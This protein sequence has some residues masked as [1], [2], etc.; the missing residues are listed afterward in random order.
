MALSPI[1]P[2]LESAN[3]E[4]RVSDHDRLKRTEAE[5]EE[6]IAPDNYS[7]DPEDTRRF[8]I[9]D[10]G[11]TN[12]K[13]IFQHLFRLNRPVYVPKPA[14]SY[15]LGQLAENESCFDL[16]ELDGVRIYGNRAL[17]TFENPGGTG[18][19]RLFNLSGTTNVDIDGIIAECTDY[20]IGTDFEHGVIVVGAADDSDPCTDIRIRIEA[21]TCLAGVEFFRA[22]TGRHT[23][24][25]IDIET[26]SCYYG[27]VFGG[28]GDIVRGRIRTTGAV[29]SYF[30]YEVR[31]HDVEVLANNVQSISGGDCVIKAFSDDSVTENIRVRYSGYGTNS[32]EPAV[33]IET[34]TVGTDTCAIRNIDLW[35][36]TSGNSTGASVHFNATRNASNED[37]TTCTIDQIWIRGPLRQ[38]VSFTTKPTSLGRILQN[39]GV[40]VAARNDMWSTDSRGWVFKQGDG[41]YWQCTK[42]SDSI[43]IDIPVVGFLGDGLEFVLDLLIYVNA[44]RGL[45][46]TSKVRAQRTTVAGYTASNAVTLRTQ[47]THYNID[48]STPGITITV[49]ASGGN[50]RIAVTGADITSD[51]VASVRYGF[52]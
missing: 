26:T 35:V 49:S 36:D 7:F 41:N 8:N 46:A 32:T 9:A 38:Q 6:N 37:P 21:I 48:T 1:F 20:A 4:L 10:D 51:G 23:R 19:A 42:L 52:V 43:N 17:F 22:D 34:S 24:I 5:I 2:Q 45:N 47:T 30:A 27:A 12:V 50:V 3:G 44:D 11:V 13:A 18:N 25:D 39:T 14:V 40:E 29:R 15:Y 33:L 16:S 28:D 31:D